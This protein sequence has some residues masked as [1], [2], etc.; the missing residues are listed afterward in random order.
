MKVAQVD[1]SYAN[2]AKAI[3]RQRKADIDALSTM[4]NCG[5]IA[6]PSKANGGL[7]AFSSSVRSLDNGQRG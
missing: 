4:A 2:D 3:W 7:Q 5:G 6:Y 1:T